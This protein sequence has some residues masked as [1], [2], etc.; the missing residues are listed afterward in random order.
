MG[1]KKEGTE[2]AVTLIQELRPGR[3]RTKSD[4]PTELQSTGSEAHCPGFTFSSASNGLLNLA[5][6]YKISLCLSFNICEMENIRVLI[7]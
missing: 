4:C 3:D 5:E 2:V 6:S 1:P 7:L